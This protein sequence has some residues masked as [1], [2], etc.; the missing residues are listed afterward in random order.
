M[1]QIPS[2]E[3]YDRLEQENAELHAK[4]KRAK[5]ILDGAN[6]FNY[7][8]AIAEALAAIREDS[9]NGPNGSD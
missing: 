2:C 8:E 6:N 4:L 5:D 3:D 9:P 1:S 7:W